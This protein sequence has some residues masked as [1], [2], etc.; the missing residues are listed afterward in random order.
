[1]RLVL[2]LA[3]LLACRGGEDSDDT[4]DTSTATTTT[5]T[6]GTTG[7]VTGATTGGTTGGITTGG[8]TGGTPCFGDLH[9]QVTTALDCSG[10]CTGDLYLGVFDGNP[11]AGNA[12]LLNGDMQPAVDLTAAP[13]AWAAST[14]PC[15]TVFVSPFLDRDGN[16]QPT[17]GDLVMATAGDEV[18]LT[19]GADVAV[20]QDLDQ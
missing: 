8:T 13:A 19:D 12:N 10:P 20:D 5:T 1:M 18:G 2:C 16:G 6:A 14:I 7:G 4:S 3:F 11:A 15:G 9:G 17:P